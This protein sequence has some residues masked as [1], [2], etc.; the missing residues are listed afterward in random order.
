MNS[1]LIS[2]FFFIFHFVVVLFSLPDLNSLFCLWFFPALQKCNLIN[3]IKYS[4]HFL[5]LCCF[6]YLHKMCETAYVWWTILV[7]WQLLYVRLSCKSN[8]N[9]FIANVFVFVYNMFGKA[10]KY[11]LTI[12]PAAF[13]YRLMSINEGKKL[14]QKIFIRKKKYCRNSFFLPLRK[15]NSTIHMFQIQSSVNTAVLCECGLTGQPN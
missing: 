13:G 4:T 15:K 5:F 6:F 9:L 14:P 10:M 2:S 1:H 7:N 11:F 3:R 8:E 12:Q